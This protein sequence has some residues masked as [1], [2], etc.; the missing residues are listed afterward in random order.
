MPCKDATSTVGLVPDPL[1]ADPRLAVL[2]DTFDGERTDLVAYLRLAVQ[3]G[4]S[5]VLDVGCGTGCFAH[6]A[7]AAGMDVIGVD[8]AAASLEVARGKPGGNEIT[9]HCGPVASAPPGPVDVAVLTGNVAQVFLTDADWLA[10]LRAIA[11]R[12]DPAG[13]LVFE[14][15]RL[16]DRVWERWAQDPAEASATVE[17]VGLVRQRR[18]LRSVQ[19]PLVSFRYTYSFA[20]GTQVTSDSTIRFRTVAE[21]RALLADAGFRIEQIRQA[22][23]RPGREDVYLAVPA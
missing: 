10:T 13:H 21:N 5:R 20:D 15:R 3:L 1:F 4:A 8:P 6:L 12:L 18:E 2:Y 11:E 22:P 23:D 19:L 7:A 16:Q 9:W 14:T 17:G